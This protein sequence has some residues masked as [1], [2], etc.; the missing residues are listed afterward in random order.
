MF[1][2]VRQANPQLTLE[3]SNVESQ[4]LS[5]VVT[6]EKILKDVELVRQFSVLPNFARVETK[7]PKKLQASSYLRE[8]VVIYKALRFLIKQKALDEGFVHKFIVLTDNR[9]LSCIFSQDEE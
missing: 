9:G 1:N 8:S 2:F 7:L 4:F 5:E 3:F 6:Q